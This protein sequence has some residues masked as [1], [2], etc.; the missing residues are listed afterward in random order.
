MRCP[1]NIAAA[2]AAL[3]IRMLGQ[4]FYELSPRYAGAL[5]PAV[6]CRERLPAGVQTVGVFV[7]ASEAAIEARVRE[8]DLAAVQLHGTESPHL[9]RKL[10]RLGC[11]VIKAFPVGATADFSA[12]AAYEE[13]CDYFLFDTQTP[14][15]GGSG[16]SFPWHFLEN[17]DGR[18]PFILSG[19]LSPADVP[20][21]RAL[22]HARMAGID[23]NSRF[24]TAPGVKDIARLHAFI[25]SLY[26]NNR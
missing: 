14:H 12:C 3:P 13:A 1:D 22:Q 23:L 24:E 26:S 10:R 8:Y 25:Q 16:Q 18:T 11:V 2:L 21:L 5:S 6:V 7:D 20:R 19:G 4:L 9:C 17:Y 15:H